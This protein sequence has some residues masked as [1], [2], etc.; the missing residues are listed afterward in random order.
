ML[1]ET[2]P[3]TPHQVLSVVISAL[4]L[5]ATFAMAVT[6]LNPLKLKSSFGSVMIL[7]HGN[8]TVLHGCTNKRIDVQA[9]LERKLIVESQRWQED[10]VT[11]V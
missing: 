4:T 8:T 5:A 6:L 7:T 3:L 9:I 11:F 10:Y 1:G 2:R